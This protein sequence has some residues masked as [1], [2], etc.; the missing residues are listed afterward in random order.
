[1]HALQSLSCTS[2][3]KEISLKETKVWKIKISSAQFRSY[4]QKNKTKHVSEKTTHPYG[5]SWAKI[6]V[7]QTY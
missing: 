3:T 7:L 2:Q 5:I 6:L 4:R 1:V